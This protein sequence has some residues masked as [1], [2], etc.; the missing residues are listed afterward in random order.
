M[1]RPGNPWLIA[2]GAM[3]AAAAAV[4]LAAIVGG[5]DWYRFFG[6]G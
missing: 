6:A 3:S 5:P 4:H 1:P 2:G